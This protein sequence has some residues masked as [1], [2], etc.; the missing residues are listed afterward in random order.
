MKFAIVFVEIQFYSTLF[1][2]IQGILE[3]S[4]EKAGLDVTPANYRFRNCSQIKNYSANTPETISRWFL[5][6]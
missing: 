6:S 5:L 4:P 3:F 1:N 2:F